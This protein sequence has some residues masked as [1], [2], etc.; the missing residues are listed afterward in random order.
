[1]LLIAQLPTPLPEV[2]SAEAMSG[3]RVLI[4]SQQ[5]SAGWFWQD[6]S[7]RQPTRLW[8]PLDLLESRLGFRRSRGLGG[9]AL[10]WFGRR[11]FIDA[12]PTRTLG[13]EVGLEVGDW[14]QAVGVQPE[15]RGSNL[16]LSLPTA[17]LQRL[18][19]ARV[20]ANRAI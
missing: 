1:M 19:R 6:G 8:L 4:N 14:L 7:P 3:D 12:I 13:D 5:V 17:R 16:N 2:R 18:R 20:P 11:A 9:D 10:E 15:R